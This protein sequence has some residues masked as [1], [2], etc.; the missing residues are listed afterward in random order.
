M[1]DNMISS[2]SMMHQ[3]LKDIKG[4]EGFRESETVG[5]AVDRARQEISN[6]GKDLCL[7]MTMDFEMIEKV[8]TIHY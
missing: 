1:V 3:L 5:E 4:M 6:M 2:R 8:N 7:P